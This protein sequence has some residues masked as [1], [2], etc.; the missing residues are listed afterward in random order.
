MKRNKTVNSYTDW[1]E[2]KYEA[3]QPTLDTLH[4]WMQIIGKIKLELCPFINQ[5]W[6]VAYY[7]NSTGMTTGRIPYKHRGLEFDFNFILHMLTISTS[8][9]Q[10][11]SIYLKPM[12]VASFYLQILDALHYLNIDVT[13]NTE[14][15]EFTNPI[16]F[17]TDTT[18]T[19]YDKQSVE[20]WWRIQLQSSFLFDTFRSTFRGKSSPVHFFWGS[21]DLSGT[22]FSGKKAQSPKIE[23]PL[24]TIMRYAEN[25][26]NFAFGFWPGDAR[27]SQAAYYSYLYPAPKGCESIN[28]GPDIAY[29]NKQ[30]AECIL[31]YDEMRKSRNPELTLLNFLETTYL[32]FAK[33]AKWDIKALLSP[34]P[35]K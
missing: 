1:P 32:E 7:V 27:F 17:D 24:G 34:T 16:P 12:S 30:L 26:E 9:N 10:I 3:W 25:E 18:H 35:F 31:P 33:L 23:G 13:I 19:S 8:D 5:W 15:S 2:L 20:K 14:P 29:F 21:F 22:R 4:M 28:T 11:V 6:E